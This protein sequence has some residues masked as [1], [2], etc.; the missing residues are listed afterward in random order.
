MY[1]NYREF[2]YDFGPCGDE[3]DNDVCEAFE[4]FLKASG[5]LQ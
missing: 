1:S 4:E 2:S 5:Q 3:D